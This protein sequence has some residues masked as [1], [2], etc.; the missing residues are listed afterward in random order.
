[1]PDLNMLRQTLVQHQSAG[2][3]KPAFKK[4]ALPAKT[5]LGAAV[6]MS[7]YET[8]FSQM[9][10]ALDPELCLEV[11]SDGKNHKP[12]QAA[13]N[14]QNKFNALHKTSDG[15]R[16]VSRHLGL[17]EKIG[18]DGS[19]GVVVGFWLDTSAIEAGDESAESDSESH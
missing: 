11:E 12:I 19:Q 3:A 8:A 6:A 1:M 15:L 9:A 7:P 10:D 18:K 14:A 13:Y 17:S 4:R 2:F 5:R 16:I